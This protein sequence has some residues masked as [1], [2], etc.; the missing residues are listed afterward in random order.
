MKACLM[1]VWFRMIAVLAVITT[2]ALLSGCGREGPGRPLQS[3]QVPARVTCPT[4]PTCPRTTPCRCDAGMCEGIDG[5]TSAVVDQDESPSMIGRADA[6]IDTIDVITDMG[7]SMAD[8][9]QDNA[10]VVEEPDPAW[11]TH[12]RIMIDWSRP[13]NDNFVCGCDNPDPVRLARFALRFPQV[14]PAE[15]RSACRQVGGD[16]TPCPVTD[17]GVS[18]AGTR[19]DARPS[20]RQRQQAQPPRPAANSQGDAGTGT[21]PSLEDRQP[22]RRALVLR[23]NDN[24]NPRQQVAQIEVQLPEEQ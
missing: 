11:I 2:H 21:V 6:S 17:A 23:R 22:M 19:R 24:L 14:N 13:S 10:D 5:G 8:A 15:T 3:V 18:D 7:V 1:I 4:C 12:D 9:G 20:V 16:F